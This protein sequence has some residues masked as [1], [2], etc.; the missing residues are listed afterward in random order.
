MCSSPAAVLAVSAAMADEKKDASHSTPVVVKKKPREAATV[1]KPA[2]LVG[3]GA[4]G[5]GVE[6]GYD[7]DGMGIQC[8]VLLTSRDDVLLL[9]L[10]LLGR[11]VKD[12]FLRRPQPIFLLLLLPL[13]ADLL[14]APHVRVL[15]MPVLKKDGRRRRVLLRWHVAASLSPSLLALLIA[16]IVDDDDNDDDDLIRIDCWWL[17]CNLTWPPTKSSSK[18]DISHTR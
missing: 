9:L 8:S 5:G 10:L 17:L 12:V 6:A 15:L 3:E 13:L 1:S 7:E 11:D 16:F 18:K 2:T 4:G 14:D